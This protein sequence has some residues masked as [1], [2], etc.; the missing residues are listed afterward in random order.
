MMMTLMTMI[1]IHEKTS[2]T[3]LILIIQGMRSWAS[4]PGARG[5]KRPKNQENSDDED[6]FGTNKL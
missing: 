1:M 6:Q 5:L 2:H 3:F 4:A